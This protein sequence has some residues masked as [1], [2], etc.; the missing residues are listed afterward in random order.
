MLVLVPPRV[1]LQ[2]AAAFCSTHRAPLPLPAVAGA[3]TNTSP[4]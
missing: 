4:A 1:A 2:F 3:N